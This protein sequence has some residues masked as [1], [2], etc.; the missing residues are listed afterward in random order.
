MQG[1]QDLYD[2]LELILEEGG[3]KT[4]INNIIA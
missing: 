4:E 3:S 1:R 2:R